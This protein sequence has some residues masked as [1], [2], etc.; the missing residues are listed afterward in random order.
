MKQ[1][2]IS[3]P[4]NQIEEIL[5]YLKNETIHINQQYDFTSMNIQN[6][7]LLQ[8]LLNKKPSNSFISRLLKSHI[9]KKQVIGTEPFEAG[10][11]SFLYE[12]YGYRSGFYLLKDEENSYENQIK[13]QKQL[14]EIID[15]IK[16]EKD[17][18]GIQECGS[19]MINLNNFNYN[20]LTRKDELVNSDFD[21]LLNPLI[22]KSI[23]NQNK[24]SILNPINENIFNYISIIIDRNYLQNWNGLE[25]TIDPTSK[26]RYEYIQNILNKIQN[27][28]HKISI[29][30]IGCSDH[31]LESQKYFNQ[32]IEFAKY[33][34]SKKNIKTI[35][36]TNNTSIITNFINEN[37]DKNSYEFQSL[38]GIDQGIYNTIIKHS[39]KGE[40][41]RLIS[42]IGNKNTKMSEEFI[43]LKNQIFI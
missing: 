33:L 43:F 1:T 22:Q 31:N 9:L 21:L 14:L 24:L 37:K 40:P 6:K 35:F 34:Q 19:L 7:K 42:P 15:M 36:Y 27:T 32:Y 4:N 12:K 30:L 29:R 2:L 39:N 18:R 25:L 3:L 5:N 11:N 13:Y 20:L 16:V 8:F 10:E 17:V 23:Q 41:V 38:Y 26:K 28:E